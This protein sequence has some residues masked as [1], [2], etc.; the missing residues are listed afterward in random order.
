MSTTHNSVLVVATREGSFPDGLIKRGMHMA[1]E[2]HWDLIA[3]HVGSALSNLMQPHRS[4]YCTGFVSNCE[5]DV[6][7]ISAAAQAEGIDF[8]HKVRFGGA[9][10][11]I[12]D[13]CS[14]LGNVKCV[15]VDHEA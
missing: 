9:E 10:A 3:L 6:A 8:T 1:H 7:P 11:A 14:E 2:Y 13:V 12:K 5:Q 15:L 4:R